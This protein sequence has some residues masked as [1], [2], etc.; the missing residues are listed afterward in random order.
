MHRVKP[1]PRSIDDATEQRA[2]NAKPALSDE[3]SQKVGYCYRL[4]ITAFMSQ[5]GF[6]CIDTKQCGHTLRV[7][8]MVSHTS[9]VNVCQKPGL[10]TGCG[11]TPSML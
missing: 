5:V 9:A 1:W 4:K 6:G 11:D 2:L 7:F 3:P 10:Q 8:G